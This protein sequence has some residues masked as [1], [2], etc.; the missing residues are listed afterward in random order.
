MR[1]EESKRDDSGLFRTYSDF[2]SPFN[3]QLSLARM[4]SA[5][6]ELKCYSAQ[7][8][9]IRNTSGTPSNKEVLHHFTKIL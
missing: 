8:P 9:S 4:P 2:Y 7:A 3:R 1:T 6:Q 5:L